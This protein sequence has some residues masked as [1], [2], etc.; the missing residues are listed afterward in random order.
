MIT[1]DF[2]SDKL[3][4][5]HLKEAPTITLIVSWKEA[6]DNHESVHFAIFVRPKANLLHSA[7]SF[8]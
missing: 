4:I 8:H 6:A 3:S 2:K 5:A 7:G 1:L